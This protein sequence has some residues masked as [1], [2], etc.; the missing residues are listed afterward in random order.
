M[1]KLMVEAFCGGGLFAVTCLIHSAL[2]SVLIDRGVPANVIYLDF[3]KKKFKV[4]HITVGDY[5]MRFGYE[6]LIVTQWIIV[7][8]SIEN[9]SRWKSIW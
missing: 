8:K 4:P 7:N 3:F 9:R 1:L 2:L 5:S 6:R